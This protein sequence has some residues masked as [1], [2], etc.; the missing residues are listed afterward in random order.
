MRPLRR[1]KAALRRF[2]RHSRRS[3][4]EPLWPPI[5]AIVAIF[6]LQL[7]LGERRTAGP[8]WL[9][10]AL[11]FALLVPLSYA[12][13][14]HQQ[15]ESA[16]RRLGSIALIALINLFNFL[17]LALLVR[18][19]L[20]GSAAD[21]TALL[22]DAVK[23]WVTNVMGFA[24]WYWELDRGGPWR[25]RLRV[26]RPPDFL[27]PQMSTPTLGDPEWRPDFADYLFVAFTNAAA[28]SPTDTL[29][30]TGRIKMLMMLQAFVSLLTV[31]IV[32]SRAVNIL[33]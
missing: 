27:F 31:A 13:L 6:A 18:E 11:E 16:L 9:A 26:P 23:L 5:L 30:L 10:P 24:L 12:A 15:R 7:T 2:A 29:P 14:M 21:G 17:S 25:R 32:A 4:A 33:K 22:L 8:N 1:F 20:R 28:F 3:G 19:L